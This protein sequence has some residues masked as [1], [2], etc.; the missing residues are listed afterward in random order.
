M[1]SCTF[2]V[3]AEMCRHPASSAVK[4]EGRLFWYRCVTHAGL[5]ANGEHVEVL[6]EAMENIG[7]SSD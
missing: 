7:E 5:R 4:G 6:T 3:G 2:P 1:K